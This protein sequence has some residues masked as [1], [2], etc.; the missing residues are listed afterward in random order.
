MRCPCCGKDNDRVVDS[1]SNADR[2]ATRRRRECLI[3]GARYTTYEHVERH[4]PRVI[5]RDG[6]RE[7]FDRSKMERGLL[8]ACQKRRI[9]SN[10]INELIDD[11]IFELERTNAAEVS[12]ELIGKLI[13]E[14]LRKLDAVAYVRFASVYS[15]F[16]DVQQFMAAV[17]DVDNG[18]TAPS[19]ARRRKA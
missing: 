14:R 19:K 15:A 17:N 8:S 4:I 10:T 7:I 13:M 2:S 5:K 1:R 12:T 18:E 16:D 6:C 11:V 3:C 9:P